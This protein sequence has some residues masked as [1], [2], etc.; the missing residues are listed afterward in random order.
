MQFYSRVC[1]GQP[2]PAVPTLNEAKLEFDL[3]ASRVK[4]D[5]CVFLALRLLLGAGMTKP[6][7]TVAV[8]RIW[9]NHAASDTPLSIVGELPRTSEAVGI[10]KLAP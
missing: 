7:S 8:H 4:G 1:L 3:F 5:H 9:P 10:L 6:S 2:P